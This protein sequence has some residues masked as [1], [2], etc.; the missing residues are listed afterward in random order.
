MDTIEIPFGAKD[1]ETLGWTFIIPEGFTAKIED[2]KIIVKKEET[3]F[4]DGI[5]E[6]RSFRRGIEEGRRLE[7]QKEQIPYTDFVIKPHKGDDNNPYDMGV[8]EAQEYAIKRG[9]GIPFN[10]GEVYVDERH[11]T[12]TIGNIIRWAD[13]HPKEQKL[14]EWSE[15]K[16]PKDIEKD[17]TQF[18]FDK[19]FNIT[20]H[21]AKEIATHYLMIGHN[22]G[23]VEGRKNAH[24]PAKELGLPSSMDFKQEWSEEEK[25]KLNSIERLIVNA[26]AHGNSLIGDK[27][28][29]DLQHFIRSLVKPVTNIA[30][31]SDED[32]MNL[33]GC[34]CSLH[35]YGYMTYAD[36]LKHLPERFNLQPK[37]EWSEEDIK[38][39]RSEEY[40]KGFNDAAFGGKLV[41]EWSE[42]DDGMLLSIIN[43]FRNGTV[44]TIGQEQ[45]LKSLHERFNLK[46]KQG[47][48]EE[49][50]N[51]L[52]QVMEI[53]L[54]DKTIVLRENPRCKALHRAYDELLDWLKSLRPQP[55]AE[56]TLLDENIITA[57]VAFVEQNDHFNFWGGID[58]HT[59]I[60]ALR[61]LKPH[62]KPSNEQME[63]LNALN[64]HGDLSYVGQQK[65][66]ISL[67]QDLK[68]LM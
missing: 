20:P 59:V 64:L 49:D 26:N 50:E 43:A 47:W 62:W 24:I 5:I 15:D 53:L 58:K 33:N 10:D 30:E 56:L 57:A 52:H 2:G 32:K 60:K 6:V 54:A 55:K 21:Q 4:T 51:K 31:W 38:K 35:Q 18:C 44:S 68:K 36:F 37:K 17:A 9:F 13:E 67:Y 8:S 19:G 1:F 28:A 41:K 45:W 14:T 22:E 11:L 42:E 39:I 27:E 66:L 3:D 29:T 40:T 12:Q 61:S 25:D 7:K 23:Y 48:G 34:I 63:A 46:P 16:F 65:Q